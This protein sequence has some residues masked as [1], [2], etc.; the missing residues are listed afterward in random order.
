MWSA[1][2]RPTGNQRTVTY[3]DKFTGNTKFGGV[4]CTVEGRVSEGPQ[5]AGN[6]VNK[7]LMK[8]N[9]SNYCP[10]SRR[11][12]PHMPVLA[13]KQFGR[14]R[15]QGL[16]DDKWNVIQQYA[17][18]P[19][20]YQQQDGRQM[21]GREA[22]LLFGAWETTS[23]ALHPVWAGSRQ[24]LTYWRESCRDSPRWPGAGAPDVEGEAER[25]ELVKNR[26]VR[27]ELVAVSS[28]LMWWYKD[29]LLSEVHRNKVGGTGHR[30]DH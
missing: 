30:T 26:G 23:G 16:V 20:W 22:C 18:H 3:L 2:W 15:P 1:M 8:L 7:S 6:W 27:R 19:G 13:G 5:L 28:Y 14:N 25:T 24:T 11:N 9:K 4:G 17:T 10:T 12:W 29:N 21:E